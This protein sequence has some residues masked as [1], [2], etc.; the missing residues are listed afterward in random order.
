MLPIPHGLLR[1]RVVSAAPERTTE[2]HRLPSHHT[3]GTATAA[4][5]TANTAGLL[6][7]LPGNEAVE[8]LVVK[9]R[10]EP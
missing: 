2:N 7:L 6:T 5:S 1:C 9:Q 4:T 3:Q 8:T 10:L